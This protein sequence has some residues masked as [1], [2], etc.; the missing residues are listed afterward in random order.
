MKMS[1]KEIINHSHVDWCVLF[2][3][4]VSLHKFLGRNLA[5]N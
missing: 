4:V 5:K 1:L 2:M 3:S